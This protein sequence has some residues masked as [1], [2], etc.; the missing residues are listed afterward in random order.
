MTYYLFS[1]LLLKLRCSGGRITADYNAAPEI[2]YIKT[3]YAKKT[4]DITNQ[5][6][7]IHVYCC[8]ENRYFFL[9]KI[10]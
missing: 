6:I 10:M 5:S 8:F 7:S 9:Q 1:R 2:L 3:F 4:K